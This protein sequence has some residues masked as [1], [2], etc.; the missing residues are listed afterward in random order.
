VRKGDL[1]H[2]GIPYTPT[3]LLLDGAGVVTKRWVGKL[4]AEKENVVLQEFGFIGKKFSENPASND[5]Y[6]PKARE[7]Y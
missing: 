5:R 3:L 1:A 2:L 6:L 4:S 7:L